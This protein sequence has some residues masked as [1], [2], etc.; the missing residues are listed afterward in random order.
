MKMLKKSA[1]ERITLEAKPVG[2]AFAFELSIKAQLLGLKIAEIPFLTVDRPFGG[3]ST[4]QVV[5]WTI[6]YMRW[7]LWGAKRL[8]RFNRIQ[9]RPITLDV[10]KDR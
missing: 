4:F 6:E 3:Q 7:F 9:K 8:N 5:P 2:W 1:F 10:L